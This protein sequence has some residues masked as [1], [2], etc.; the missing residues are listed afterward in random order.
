MNL[1]S[2]EQVRLAET[3]IEVLREVKHPHI[4]KLLSSSIHRDSNEDQG[5]SSYLLLSWYQ[6]ESK[7]LI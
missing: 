1:A 6:V 7:T 5:L 3:E 4:I 2:D